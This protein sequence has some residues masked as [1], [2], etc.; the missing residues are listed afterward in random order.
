MYNLSIFIKFHKSC[1]FNINLNS[2]IKMRSKNWILLLLLFILCFLLESLDCLISELQ[3]LGL[4]SVQVLWAL[5]CEF[6]KCKLETFG[7]LSKPGKQEGKIGVEEEFLLSFLTVLVHRI[8]H[9]VKVYWLLNYWSLFF[10]VMSV[11][12]DYS[13]E[14]R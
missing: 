10:L 8:S 3:D 5:V 12:M 11:W 6:F 13:H 1:D 14:S 4:H 7:R 9:N 2:H